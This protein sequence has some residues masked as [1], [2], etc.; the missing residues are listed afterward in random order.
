MQKSL[1]PTPEQVGDIGARYDAAIATHYEGSME[2]GGDIWGVRAIDESRFAVYVTD[3][4][5]HGVGAALNTFRF[6]TF[7]LR[8]ELALA[9]P[10]ASM[11]AFN[12]FLSGVLQVGQYATMFYG[13]IDIAASRLRYVSA[14]APVPIARIGNDEEC[15]CLDSTGLPLGIAGDSEYERRE[16]E[17]PPG[18]FLFLYSDALIE[19]PSMSDP[20]F[21]PETLRRHLTE[22][23]RYDSP[24]RAVEE[25]L[26]RL[27][28][29][30]PEA[31]DDDLTILSLCRRGNEGPRNDG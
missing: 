6:H 8:P 19:T 23:R 27:N 22:A 5:G 21:L 4:S 14:A 18:S 10:L 12:G 3:F 20:V 17:F 24:A 25:T 30:A 11:V 2:L 16:I 1:L 31:I 26:D 15:I 13:V 7:M 28:A 9:D 29:E